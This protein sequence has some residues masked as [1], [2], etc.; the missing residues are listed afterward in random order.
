[1][2]PLKALANGFRGYVNFF[3]RASRSEFWWWT[4]LNL[5]FIGAGYAL[6]LWADT[7]PQDG[8]G[9]GLGI[10]ALTLVVWGVIFVIPDTALASRRLNDAGVSG[11]WGLAV[12]VPWVGFLAIILFGLLP[13]KNDFERFTVS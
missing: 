2:S 7:Q 5:A 8:A 1:M 11:L 4:A 9:V 3:G 10:L 13:S 6:A 12:L